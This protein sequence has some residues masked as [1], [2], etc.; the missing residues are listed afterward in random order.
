MSN[1]NDRNSIRNQ[2]RTLSSPKHKKHKYIN[3]ISHKHAISTID[4]K[5][6]ILQCLSI[7]DQCMCILK[8][9]WMCYTKCLN[10]DAGTHMYDLCVCALT[11]CKRIEVKIYLWRFS[12][13]EDD[14]CTR[15]CS[16]L[17]K[18]LFFKECPKQQLIHT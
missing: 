7:R 6:A 17:F 10:N 12:P 5:H 8:C 9:V 16:S 14:F 1:R 11:R 13:L 15:S 4:V 18:L 3:T 2:I